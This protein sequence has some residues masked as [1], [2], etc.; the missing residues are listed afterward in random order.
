MVNTRLARALFTRTSLWSMYLRAFSRCLLSTRRKLN[1][2]RRDTREHWVVSNTSFTE[3][4]W[5]H[6]L[7]RSRSMSTVVVS[8]VIPSLIV[9]MVASKSE[10]KHPQKLTDTKKNTTMKDIVE[11]FQNLSDAYAEHDDEGR[12]ASFARV[13]ES[14]KCLRTITCGADIAN[15]QGVGQAS[16]DIVDEFLETGK[17][18]RLEELMDTEMKIQ[19]R[20]KQLLAMDRPNNKHTM[21]AFVL[22]KHPYVKTCAKVAKDL[23]TGVDVHVKVALAD[24]LKKDGYLPD[25]EIEDIRCDTCHLYRDEGCSEECACDELRLGR[26]A[27]ALGL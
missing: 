1:A 7:S 2:F 9:I 26:L 20:T 11:L 10:A 25:Y 5:H 17:C 16:V 4:L 12:S 13:A 23:L 27:W 15:L 3:V 14:I 24:L 21:K 8:S 18:Q 22:V 19:M 6:T